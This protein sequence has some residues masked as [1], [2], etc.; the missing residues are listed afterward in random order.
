MLAVLALA[1][2]GAATAQLAIT[3]PTTRLLILPLS[4][5]TAADSAMS[6]KV[7]DTVRVRLAVL[8]KYKV[9]V[10]PKAKL[11]EA[12][13]ASGF[14][15]DLLLPDAQ[16][17]LLARLLNAHAYTGGTLEHAAQGGALVARVRV[18]D[19]GSSGLAFAFSSTSAPAGTPAALS[20]AIAQRLNTIVK[21]GEP[22]RECNDKRSKAQFNAALDAARKAIAIEPDLPAAHLCMATVYE[23]Q[24]MP[25]D[26]LIAEARRATR[27]DSMNP[28]AW[29]TIARTYQVKGDTLN[30]VDAFEKELA[31]DPGNQRLRLAMADML[32][33]QKQYQ[34]AVALLDA[35]LAVA[36]ADEKLL[37]LRSR[38]CIEGQL[39]QC[40]LQGFV[41][42][43]QADSTKLADTS[44]LKA[45]LG[46]AQQVPDTQ[47]L[48][49]FGRAAVRR[50]PKSAA[51]WKALGQAY[52]LKGLPDSAVAAYR[53]SLALDPNDINSSLLVA[54]TIVDRSMYDTVQANRL[55][56]DSVALQTLRNAF[57]DRLDTAKIYLA[58]PVAAGDSAQ[59]LSAAVIYLTGGS[60]IA[61]TGAYDRA[62][63]W[64][65]QS[66]KLVAPRTPG[67][68]V[69]PRQ[70]IRVQA[71]FWYGVSSVQP[72]FREY[73]VMVKSKS[74]TQAKAVNDWLERA[75]QALT[76]GSRVH[77]PT[78][79]S[80][81]QNLA[82]LE[83]IMPQVKK[84]FQCRNF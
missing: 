4:V 51:F 84:Q 25:S 78:A 20:E 73:G 9:I 34:R 17:R 24:R 57:A 36:P 47:Q 58:R 55:K 40:T 56:K 13:Q 71:S 7:M 72:L 28:T 50:F 44:F 14:P 82:K 43:A 49:F 22:A 59:K 6:V 2:P 23:A 76:L 30:A 45:A 69:G 60:K 62:Y 15:C 52:D 26:S 18:V 10:I 75:K 1:A 63:P 39:W 61:Q 64:L 81:L 42:Q 70:Q 29:E 66:L 12:L 46:A 21:A 8:A 27:G 32:R 80:M 41:A 53:A 79:N 74:C 19:M 11:C 83:A 48:L 37:D 3:Q 16:A 77:P 38:I 54:K 33:Q 31:G 35:G 5:S 67:D 68:T 65:E